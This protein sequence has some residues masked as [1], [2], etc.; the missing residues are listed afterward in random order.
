VRHN[1][2]E[3]DSGVSGDDGDLV[4]LRIARGLPPV[5]NPFPANIGGAVNSLLTLKNDSNTIY[6]GSVNGG[7]WKTIDGGVHWTPLTDSLP[8][9]SISHLS[10]DTT[11]PTERTIVASIGSF[12]NSVYSYGHALGVY[13]TNDGGLSWSIPNPDEFL[14]K[15]IYLTSSFKIGPTIVSCIRVWSDPTLQ[16]AIY[17]S[18]D[19]GKTWSTRGPL[20]NN[21]NSSCHHMIHIPSQNTFVAAIYQPSSSLTHSEAEL[22]MSQDNGDTW[23]LMKR[24]TGSEFLEVR[25]SASLDSNH[26]VSG[27]GFPSSSA[28]YYLL[29]LPGNVQSL[30]VCSPISINCSFI[31][32]TK[33]PLSF[34]VDFQY[35][36]NMVLYADPTNSSNVYMG[37]AYYGVPYRS[38]IIQ[39]LRC[40]VVLSTGKANCQQLAMTGYTSDVSQPHADTRSFLLDA[41]GNLLESDDGGIWKR[42]KPTRNDGQWL[43]LNGDIRTLECVSATYDPVTG[44]IACGA[45]DNGVSMGRAGEPWLILTGGDGA[46]VRMAYQLS[47]TRLF[48]SAQN[49]GFYY[50]YKKQCAKTYDVFAYFDLDVFPF[51]TQKQLAGINLRNVT[52]MCELQLPDE[53]PFYTVYEINSVSPADD[54][55]LVFIGTTFI[56]EYKWSTA[57]FEIVLNL[58]YPCYDFGGIVAG[59]I[60]NGVTNSDLLI[61]ACTDLFYRIA[62]GQMIK[63]NYNRTT[64]GSAVDL[65]TD[66]TD[67]TVIYVLTQKFLNPGWETHVLKT[68]NFGANFTDI[69]S[70][71]LSVTMNTVDSLDYAYA[72]W[73]LAAIK[74]TLNTN[75]IFVSGKG[76]VFYANDP[77]N[78]SV[79]WQPLSGFP[80]VTTTELRTPPGDYLLMSTVGR[81]VWIL[82]NASY[83]LTPISNSPSATISL[84]PSISISASPSASKSRTPVP[85]KTPAHH[86][87]TSHKRSQKPTPPSTKETSAGRQS[88]STAA[89]SC[90]LFLCYLLL[91]PSN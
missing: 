68:T 51:Q 80:S 89:A 20:V 52:Q 49:L 85:T 17:V 82:S 69:T 76:G 11:D 62:P 47:P 19:E 15:G 88:T 84:T 31:N 53:M 10:F 41:D 4:H 38:K 5:F 35:N 26:S 78:S 3:L 90:L 66:P 45:Q 87:Q 39:F 6:A 13:I 54:L 48:A 64:Y 16:G 23:S 34:A 61:V 58:T 28:L 77:G 27:V 14:S 72:F 60:I 8:S 63:T 24:I 71:L 42:T 67:A 86:H 12:T 7:V 30:Y 29:G 79:T 18:N 57:S 36:P 43:S 32:I 25:I 2:P 91:L 50:G 21:I 59:G 65:A 73:S 33:L 81:G 37:G 9:L 74:S 56:F 22:W 1:G 75:V 40:G 46:P 83:I 55:R 70:N 44:L